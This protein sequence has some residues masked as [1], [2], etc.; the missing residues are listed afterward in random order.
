VLRRGALTA[1]P[2]LAAY[3]VMLGAGTLP[4]ARTVAFATVVATQLSQTLEAGRAEGPL[5][6]SVLAAVAGSGGLLVAALTVPPLR[7]ALALAVPSPLGWALIGASTVGVAG[8]S[9]LL[10]WRGPSVDDASEGPPARGAL[11]PAAV[12]A[13]R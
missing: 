5:S 8:A 12:M 7:A 1:A 3:M 9:R 4:Q 6:R 11:R 2:S 13:R 10:T